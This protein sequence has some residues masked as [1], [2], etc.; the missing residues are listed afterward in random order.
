MYKF[1]SPVRISGYRLTV[2]YAVRKKSVFLE[3]APISSLLHRK[4][5]DQSHAKP[6]YYGKEIG[7]H[8][9]LQLTLE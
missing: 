7:I 2:C 6:Q 3:N 9:T 1:V 8:S 5:A 4:L